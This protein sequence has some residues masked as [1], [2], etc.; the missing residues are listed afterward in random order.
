MGNIASGR[1]R[2]RQSITRRSRNRWRK[3][4]M[5]DSIKDVREKLLHGSFEEAEKAFMD[6]CTVIDKA[7]GKGVVHKNTAA[8]TKSRL[9]A[10]LKARKSAG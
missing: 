8:R 7:A 1:K 10:R 2:H 9:S 4:A 3:T 5:R 6:T